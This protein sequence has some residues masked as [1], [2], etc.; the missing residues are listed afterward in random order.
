MK[1]AQALLVASLGCFLSLQ[2]GAEEI[3]TGAETSSSSSLAL[4]DSTSA[5]KSSSFSVSCGFQGVVNDEDM[6]TALNKAAAACEAAGNVAAQDFYNQKAAACTESKTNCL[7]A[8]YKAMHQSWCGHMHIHPVHTAEPV[9][10]H[11]AKSM[12]TLIEKAKKACL[13]STDPVEV[14]AA[15]VYF[16]EFKPGMCT[17]EH[18]QGEQMHTAPER[19]LSMYHAIGANG[20]PY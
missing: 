1:I 13:A 10:L 7:E 12:D 19:C 4:A 16:E 20:A 18:V 3:L 11:W 8:D 9:P 14:E 6:Q 15:T 2:V 5:D 17:S